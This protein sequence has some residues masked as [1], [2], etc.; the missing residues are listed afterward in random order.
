MNCKKENCSFTLIE[1]VLA[2]MIFAI[3]AGMAAG[4]FFSLTGSWKIQQEMTG[5][6][7]EYLAM[8]HAADKIV[9]NM[10]PIHHLDENSESKPVFFG[11]PQTMIAAYRHDPVQGKGP[12]IGYAAMGLRNHQLILQYR[13]AP[14][15]Y[16]EEDPLPESLHEEI[17]AD[18]VEKIQFLYAEYE[19]GEL[20]W[21]EDWDEENRNIL[22]LAVAWIITYQDGTEEKFLRRT[23][24]IS[25]YT[26]YGK[27]NDTRDL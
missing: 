11:N 18:H 9:R 5:R 4:S 14:I 1:V 19:N 22:P 27:R 20:V 7:Q 16:F 26:A 21:Q 15:L 17:L 25:Y 3:L 23:T 12:A 8:E 24:G 10:L 2:V 13:D 6:L